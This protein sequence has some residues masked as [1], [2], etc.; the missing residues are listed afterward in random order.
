MIV[1]NLTGQGFL[2]ELTINTRG[3]PE[4]SQEEEGKKNSS[5][6]D[7][8]S[9]SLTDIVLMLRSYI[10]HFPLEACAVLWCLI[11]DPCVNI[12]NIKLV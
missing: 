2:R 12:Y 1:D 10:D 4:I 8:V 9:S 7:P 11:D 5:S 3:L 6:E